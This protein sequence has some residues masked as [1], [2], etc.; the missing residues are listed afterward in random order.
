M[1]IIYAFI[2]IVSS[3]SRNAPSLPDLKNKVSAIFM[4]VVVFI[5]TPVTIISSALGIAGSSVRD[6]IAFYFCLACVLFLPKK[7]SEVVAV[8]SSFIVVLFM[9]LFFHHIINDHSSY[10]FSRFSGGAKNPNQLAL[11]LCCSVVLLVWIDGTFSRVVVVACSV[12]FGIISV[13]EAYVAFLAISVITM[14]LLLIIP[15]RVTL[16]MAPFYV[17]VVLFF[18]QIDTVWE[19]LSGL[20]S[21]ADEGGA[22][23]VLFIYGLQAWSD[24]FLSLLIGFGAGSYSGF[25]GPFEGAEAHNT[26]IDMVSIAGIFGLVLFPGLTLY[27][28]AKSLNAGSLFGSAVFFALIC[29]CMFHFVGRQPIFWV[30]IVLFSRYVSNLAAAKK[31]AMIASYSARGRT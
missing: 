12:Y 14:A 1:F 23:G 8:V 2:I 28:F 25:M 10:Y 21:A 22:R 15:P 29:F 17:F 19:D 9:S 4:S 16:V 20:W 3:A 24:N 11:F 5:I 6:L 27:I 18:I 31:N 30:T 7:V 26:M 13:S